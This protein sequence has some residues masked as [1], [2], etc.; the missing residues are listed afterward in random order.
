[1]QFLLANLHLL[2]A[3]TL[4]TIG[5]LSPKIGFIFFGILLAFSN[6]KIFHFAFSTY[7]LGGIFLWWI[8]SIS[9]K[10]QFPVKDRI[11]LPWICYTFA[12][13][14]SFLKSNYIA[15]SLYLLSTW[16]LWSLILVVV[17]NMVRNERILFTAVHSY[18]IAGVIVAVIAL[19]QYYITRDIDPQRG[20]GSTF[21]DKNGMA[22]FLVGVVSI[23]TALFTAKNIPTHSKLLYAISTLSAFTVIIISLSRGAWIG[24][25]AVIII[26]LLFQPR[27]RKFI[28]L[29]IIIFVFLRPESVMLRAGLVAPETQSQKWVVEN[30]DYSDR[31]RLAVYHSSWNMFKE[32]PL[33]G[34]G[35]GTYGNRISNYFSFIKG[36]KPAPH[37]TF[38]QILAEEGIIGL[39][40]FLWLLYAFLKRGYRIRRIVTTDLA[41][42]LNIGMLAGM[43][44]TLVSC[45]TLDGMNTSAHWLLFSL[46][47]VFARIEEHKCIIAKEDSNSVRYGSKSRKNNFTFLGQHPKTPTNRQSRFPRLL[48]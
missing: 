36:Y 31:F 5:F 14:I 30:R 28:L 40:A 38:V 16:L 3:L 35:Y 11:F 6:Y 26:F 13:F 41:R 20:L 7:I 23:S 48:K 37:N 27:A 1:M 25:V 2:L 34:V 17:I 43:V 10:R 18:I 22:I 42:S 21:G 44:G 4:I 47:I 12:V 45:L 19:Y 39:L 24:L 9:L 46:A 15:A 32:S 29:S 8:I 33:I